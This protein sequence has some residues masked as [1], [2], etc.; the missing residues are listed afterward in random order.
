[1]S[2]VFVV[3]S[4]RSEKIHGSEGTITSVRVATLPILLF[5]LIAGLAAAPAAA[6]VLYGSVVGGVSLVAIVL[7][8]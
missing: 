2:A 1:M 4:E 5:L 3:F 7:L 6:Q 8:Y